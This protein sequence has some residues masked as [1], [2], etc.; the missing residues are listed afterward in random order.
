MMTDLRLC[1][2]TVTRDMS[3]MAARMRIGHR[4]PVADTTAPEHRR[5]LGVEEELLLF[6]PGT[7]HLAPAGERLVDGAQGADEVPA[8]LPQVE[9]ELKRQQVETVTSPQSDLD[10][11][12]RQI[13]HGRAAVALRGAA[14]GAAPAAM[15][16]FP[17]PGRPVPTR[18]ERYERMVREFG[19]I[20]QQ[21]L[22]CGMHVHVAVQSRDEGIAVVDRLRPWLSVL[23]AMSA[24]SPFHDGRDTGYASYRTILQEMW[25]SA[26]ATELFHTVAAYEEHVQELI[27]VGS[28]LDEGMIYFDARLSMRF[29][30]VEIRVMDVTP[31]PERATAL[32]ALC[33]ALVD[34]AAEEWRGGVP[35]VEV[36]RATL[37]GAAWRAARWGLGGDL[38]RPGTTQTAPAADVVRTLVEHCQEALGRNGDLDRVRSGVD[39][40][41]AEGT[42][43]DLQRAAYARHEDI[44][45]VVA[46]AVAWTVPDDA[47]VAGRRPGG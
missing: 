11:L 4:E 3:R 26:G 47:R 17:S 6:E 33:R 22:T 46:A 23:L 27:G 1:I 32:V 35:P 41:L 9:H 12:E 2:G 21:Q 31:T 15:G 14:E 38:V 37:R 13:A 18:D 28:A 19:S 36:R 24:N 5:T 43:A 10:S 20:G 30:T 45:D 7:A 39:L 40:L 16:T 29:P 42:G 25:P 8:L 44:A 34:T